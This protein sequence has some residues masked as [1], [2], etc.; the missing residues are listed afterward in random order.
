MT[1]EQ[2]PS[3]YGGVC[4]LCGGQIAVAQMMYHE[5]KTSKVRHTNCHAEVEGESPFLTTDEQIHAERDHEMWTQQRMEDED[6]A[7]ERRRDY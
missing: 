7:E 2:K 1:W 3:R 6:R 4:E 5:P